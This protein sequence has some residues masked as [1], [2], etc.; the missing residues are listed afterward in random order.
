MSSTV[1]LTATMNSDRTVLTVAWFFV[2]AASFLPLGTLETVTLCL[3]RAVTGIPC[4]GCG[5]GHSLYEFFN[6]DW[7]AA[8]AYHPLGPVVAVTWTGWTLKKWMRLPHFRLLHFS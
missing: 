7:L 1:S 4:F 3:F 8:F 2:I 5:M 6:G